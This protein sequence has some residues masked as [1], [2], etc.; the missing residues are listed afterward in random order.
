MQS[1]DD[2]RFIIIDFKGESSRPLLFITAIVLAAKS[3]ASPWWCRCSVIRLGSRSVA[4]FTNGPPR[5]H[6]RWRRHG[7]VPL[8]PGHRP[9]RLRPECVFSQA[10]HGPRRRDC[11][12]G[13]G[14]FEL[15]NVV[16][17]YPTE[18]SHR[19][20]G[21]HPNSGHRDYSRLSCGGRNTQLGS[22]C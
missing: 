21:I 4:S 17:N 18:E 9:G 11:L 7:N 5:D 22:G 3:S 12:A 6:S 14:G 20:A 8:R 2:L 19:F 15:R 16:A 10:A 13:V 1:F